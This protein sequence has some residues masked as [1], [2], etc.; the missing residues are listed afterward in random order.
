MKKTH[1]LIILWLIFLFS[2]YLSP[3]LA[4]KI[5]I[6]ADWFNLDQKKAEIQAV[7]NVHITQN[8]LTIKAEKAIYN[9]NKKRLQVNGK[10]SFRY[11]DIFGKAG[12]AYYNINNKEII[13]EK[14]ASIKRKKEVLKGEMIHFNLKDRK[15][16]IKGKTNII[17]SLDRLK[18]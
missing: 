16:S 4:Q 12:V 6:T 17:L 14:K 10:I 9:L 11:K 7:G 8:D 15:I 13:L 2:A 1:N 3:L 5:Q 18:K